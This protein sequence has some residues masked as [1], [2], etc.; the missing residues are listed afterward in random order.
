MS[1]AATPAAE[2][3]TRGEQ[4]SLSLSVSEKTD[5]VRRAGEIQVATGE[6]T[7]VQDYIRSMLFPAGTS[8][9]AA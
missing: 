1:E 8:D 7:T 6:T 4:I 5:L 9:V 3:E 2:P